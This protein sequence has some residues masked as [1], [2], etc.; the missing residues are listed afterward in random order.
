MKKNELL[1]FLEEGLT[2]EE[3]PL[4]TL[5][6]EIDGLI[7]NYNYDAATKKYLKQGIGLL[8][9]ETIEHSKLFT[10]LLS[11]VTKSDKNEY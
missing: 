6:D 3:V 2:I 11:A 8:K 9:R 10:E 4:L 5:L 1:L 7:E